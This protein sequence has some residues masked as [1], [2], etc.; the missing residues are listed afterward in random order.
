MKTTSIG[1]IVNRPMADD[2]RERLWERFVE[3][4]WSSA[5]K[6]PTE[7]IRVLTTLITP[8][9][10]RRRFGS[11]YALDWTLAG[12]GLRKLRHDLTVL[13]DSYQPG[14]YP[15]TVDTT[16]VPVE[17]AREL[18]EE[19]LERYRDRVVEQAQEQ[20]HEPA[21]INLDAL[22]EAID[23]ERCDVTRHHLRRIQIVAEAAPDIGPSAARVWTVHRDRDG[24]GRQFEISPGLQTLRRDVRDSLVADVADGV[25]TYDV[26]FSNC[27]PTILA[28]QADQ[29][30]VD[31]PDILQDY[32]NDPDTVRK[33]V[34]GAKD[35]VLK[36]VHLSSQRP[37]DSA[38]AELHDA[39]RKLSLSMLSVAR[40]KVAH[41][42]E[43][44]APQIISR[45]LQLHERDALDSLIMRLRVGEYTPGTLMFDGTY[46]YDFKGLGAPEIGPIGGLGVTVRRVS[47][48]KS[49]PE[50]AKKA[51]EIAP[52]DTEFRRALKRAM[53]EGR[54]VRCHIGR[55]R[56]L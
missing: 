7:A 40:D 10:I 27:F 17:T 9:P 46:V 51:P 30:G 16:W 38:A 1:A 3:A 20:G 19:A 47:K 5:E 22:S 8:H 48:A 2:E 25:V 4:F 24:K 39:A 53:A 54:D 36:A 41:S 26:D 43:L 11:V 52:H 32:I 29:E 44:R 12:G 55:G 33:N 23:A 45:W 50:D 15:K 49:A 13:D 21:L 35:A 31:V 14:K 34:P 37:K 6:R 56:F 28:R 42:E 18:L